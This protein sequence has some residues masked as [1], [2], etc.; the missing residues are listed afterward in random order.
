MISK[1]KFKMYFVSVTGL[2][3]NDGLCKNEEM[4]SNDELEIETYDICGNN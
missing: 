2:Y 1:T 3:K 4:N